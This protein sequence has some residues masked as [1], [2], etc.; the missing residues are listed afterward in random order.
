MGDRLPARRVGFDVARLERL[1]AG[2][3]FTDRAEGD[4]E[5][6]RALGVLELLK[7]VRNRLVRQSR[8]DVLLVVAAR[9]DNPVVPE[10][11]Y[12]VSAWTALRVSFFFGP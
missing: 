5:L 8:L 4:D 3:D 10:A 12:D 11:K 9:F 1:L 6:G 7:N 2:R